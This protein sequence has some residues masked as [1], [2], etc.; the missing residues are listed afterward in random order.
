[1]EKVFLCIIETVISCLYKGGL[2]IKS[3]V[4]MI[5]NMWIDSKCN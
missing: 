4:N 3:E 1:M 5:A 2:D